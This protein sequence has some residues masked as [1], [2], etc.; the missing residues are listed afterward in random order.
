[1]CAFK[2]PPTV[3]RCAAESEAGLVSY[4]RLAS[5]VCLE[6][7]SRSLEAVRTVMSGL[8]DVDPALIASGQYFVADMA[9]ELVGGAGW[10]VP[11]L[12]YFP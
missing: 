9:G 1:M 11:P 5:L 7:P 2:Q 4:L 10:S 6:M 8:P 12:S 3:F